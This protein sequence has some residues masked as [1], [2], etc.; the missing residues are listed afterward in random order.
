[1]GPEGFWI[2]GSVISDLSGI[3]GGLS[4]MSSETSAKRGVF[5]CAKCLDIM[6]ACFS[7]SGRV[8]RTSVQANCQSK[9]SRVLTTSRRLTVIC[10][11][12]W[13]IGV[14][15]WPWLHWSTNIEIHWNLGLRN[16]WSMLR[17]VELPVCHLQIEQQN[18]SPAKPLQEGI[19]AYFKC[20][21]AKWQLQSKTKEPRQ[22]QT[23]CCRDRYNCNFLS[24]SPQTLTGSHR[25]STTRAQESWTAH[26]PRVK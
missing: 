18:P 10:H 13:P 24:L 17:P 20:L 15:Q 12:S 21:L 23:R 6:S 25:A 5:A 1:M 26:W 7:D 8:S 9:Q 2:Q 3:E 22:N 16:G 4:R 11:N 19:P 14:V